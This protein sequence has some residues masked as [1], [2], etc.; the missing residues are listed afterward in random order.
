MDNSEVIRSMVDDIL[1]NRG[2]EASEKI[3]S[4]LSV[5]VSDMLADKKIEI[6]STLGKQEHE[7]V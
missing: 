5:K 6:A 3:N 1:N 2:T 4:L 7:E